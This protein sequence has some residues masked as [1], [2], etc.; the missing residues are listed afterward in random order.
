MRSTIALALA[1]L[2]TPLPASAASLTVGDRE[3]ILTLNKPN[4]WPDGSIGVLKSGSV[5]TFYAANGHGHSTPDGQT[6]RVTG[7]LDNP[8]ADGEASLPIEDLL[9]DFNYIGGGPIYTGS[10]GLMLMF[11]HSERWPGGNGKLFWASIGLAKSTDGG[12]TWTDLGLIITH[13]T[14]Y[15][16]SA[17]YNTE[18]GSGAFIIKREKDGGDYF[19]SYFMNRLGNGADFNYA[20]VSVARARVSDVVSAAT[21]NTAPV[22]K[23]YCKGS[24]T[25]GT[26]RGSCAKAQSPWGEPGLGGLS[27]PLEAANMDAIFATVSYNSYLK[28]Y[29]LVGNANQANFDWPASDIIYLESKD[30]LKWSGRKSV[31]NEENKLAF[32]P[33]IIDPGPDPRVTGPGFYV[34][35]VFSNNPTSEAL[36]S[37]N[38]SRRLI[39]VNLR[40]K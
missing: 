37:G 18:I 39:T 10:S 23:K 30:G 8:L 29:I 33:T 9:D 22:F 4:G 21:A 6:R 24:V 32:Y 3:D 34:Y 14:P 26:F 31:V 40:G 1:L 25:G 12:D 19:Y 38:L 27:S 15:N 36:S 17:T 35:Y 5:Y 11:Y 28:K 7:T 2:L 16:P 13:H 20:N